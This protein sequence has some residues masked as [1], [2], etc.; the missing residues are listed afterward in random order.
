MR[1]LR[2]INHFILVVSLTLIFSGAAHASLVVTFDRIDDTSIKVTGS[3]QL[4]GLIPTNNAHFL[5]FDNTFSSLLTGIVNEGILQSSN[6]MLG[7]AGFAYGYTISTGY[8]WNGTSSGFYAGRW[9]P[10][11]A[12]GDAFD[13]GVMDISI[14]GVANSPVWAATGSTGTVYWGSVAAGQWT[15]IDSSLSPVPIPAA[16]WLFGTAL[17]GFVGLSRK[18]K[19]S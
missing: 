12:V 9:S 19:V 16:I 7:T 3:G 4:D 15:M 8:N 10:S 18:R 5:L 11:Y 14:A 13:S 2:S 17:I 1:Y 6:L